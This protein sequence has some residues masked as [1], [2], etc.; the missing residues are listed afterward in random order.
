MNRK[1]KH[2][3]LAL[4]CV[5][6]MDLVDEWSKDIICLLQTK[7]TIACR[8]ALSVSSALVREL[9][10]MP[11]AFTFLG[12]VLLD[13]LINVIKE[14]Y[15]KTNHTQALIQIADIFMALVTHCNIPVETLLQQGILITP[16]QVLHF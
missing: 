6:R 14:G 7:D 16:I 2:P 1:L 3:E 11:D 5:S 4:F 15:Q 9:K 13:A 12:K 10:G 8:S